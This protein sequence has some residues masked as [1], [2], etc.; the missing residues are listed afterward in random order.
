M[1]SLMIDNTK[2]LINILTIESL[3]TI[4]HE[5][6][7]FIDACA[8]DAWTALTFVDVELTVATLRE[9]NLYIIYA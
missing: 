3:R 7:D 6:I 4:T 9:K 8:F 5:H 2:S 1:I